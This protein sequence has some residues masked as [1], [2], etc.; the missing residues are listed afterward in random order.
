MNPAVF[1]DA[2]VPIYAAGREHRYKEPCARVLRHC[3]EDP[4]MFVTD[5]EILQELLHRYLA[6]GRWTLGREVVRAFAE[7]MNGRI[8]PVHAEDVILATELADLHPGVS[9]R[10]L[11]HAAVMQRLKADRIISADTDFDRLEGINRLDPAHMDE[12]DSSILVIPEA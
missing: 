4:Q 5:S 6:S 2:N 10:D 8:E 12:W 3:A 7:A 9:A 11:V 1:I